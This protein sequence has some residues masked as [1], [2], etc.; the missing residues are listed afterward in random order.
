M[1]DQKPGPKRKEIGRNVEVALDMLAPLLGVWKGQGKGGYPTID[2]FAYSETLRF[3]RDPG[4]P[5]LTYE[6]KTDLIDPEGRPIRKSHWEAGILRPLADGSIELACVQGSGRV[7]ILRGKFL[8]VESPS[9]GL[10]LQFQ[11]EL[12]GNDERVR[13]SSREWF[14][15]GRHFKYVMK[16]ATSSVEEP[17]LHVEANLFKL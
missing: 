17:T 9:E 6:Q 16:M 14:L 3:L 1:H 8:T 13:S 10:S 12:I 11:S 5:Y 2:E 15:T 4:A 7:E